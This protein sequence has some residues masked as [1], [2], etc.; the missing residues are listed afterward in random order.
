MISVLLK[1]KEGV[2]DATS[3]FPVYAPYFGRNLRQRDIESSGLSAIIYF[4][5]KKTTSVAEQD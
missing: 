3:I 1:I 4:S 5:Q 2:S